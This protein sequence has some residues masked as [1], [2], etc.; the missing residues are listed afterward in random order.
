[1]KEL[2]AK[3]TRERWVAPLA[4]GCSLLGAGLLI[5]ALFPTFVSQVCRSSPS[6]PFGCVGISASLGESPD[7]WAV[8]WIA[9]ILAVTAVLFLA[10]VSGLLV[11]TL[12]AVASLAALGLA[13]F[14]GVVAFPH[15]LDSAELVP[16][17]ISHALGPGYYLFLAGGALAVGAA[18]A[19]AMVLARGDAASEVASHAMVRRWGVVAIGRASLCVLAAACVGTLLPFVTLHC[20]FGCPP[21]GPPF[22]KYSGSLVA[23]LDGPIVITLLAAAGLATAIRM[24]GQG[25]VVASSAALVLT[26]AA[27]VLVSFDSLNGATRVL[28]WSYGIPTVPDPG[29]YVL[30]IGTASCVILS[31][32][33]VTADQPT[34]G[35]LRRVGIG[36]REPAPSS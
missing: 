6:N 20:G 5:A 13:I 30:Q 21:F 25:K 22:A 15:V 36:R 23:G 7:G 26:L 28:G 29:Y 34:S 10:R 11:A 16:G 14:E 4:G 3:S 33:L 19:M 32:L 24:A 8:A 9:G 2:R 31:V 35:L 12:N 1:V 18:T 17:G 27:A